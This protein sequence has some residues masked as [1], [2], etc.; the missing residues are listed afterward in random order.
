VD[1]LHSGIYL[2]ITKSDHAKKSM[3][4]VGSLAQ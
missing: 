4:T 2:Q 1:F 3:N